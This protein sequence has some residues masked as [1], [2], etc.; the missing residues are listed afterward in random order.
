MR[1]SLGRCVRIYG[2]VAQQATTRRAPS[3][4][5]PSRSSGLGCSEIPLRRCCILCSSIDHRRISSP[6]SDGDGD[7][8]NHSA[9]AI[10]QGAEGETQ[11]HANTLYRCQVTRR[12]AQ[13]TQRLMRVAVFGKDMQMQ[14]NYRHP[15]KT[16]IAILTRS[17]SRRNRLGSPSTMIL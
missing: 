6:E 13:V 17:R 3:A 10:I 16:K 14:I 8:T 2:C 11:E 1:V 7:S 4:P 5:V 12:S 9:P 15:S